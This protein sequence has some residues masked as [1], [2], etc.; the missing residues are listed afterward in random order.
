MRTKA[1]AIPLKGKVVTVLDAA[2][3]TRIQYR[4]MAQ[5]QRFASVISVPLK[6]GENVIGALRV[7]T[8]EQRHFSND[9]TKFL[10]AVAGLAATAVRNAQLHQ[11]TAGFPVTSSEALPSQTGSPGIPQDLIRPV[12]FFHPSE[13]EF[14]RLLDFYKIGVD[15]RAPLIPPEVE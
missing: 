7:Y 8:H 15:V 5:R 10:T 6:Q 4:E 13:E 2:T 12:S 14:A 1:S 9:D 11:L 3:D